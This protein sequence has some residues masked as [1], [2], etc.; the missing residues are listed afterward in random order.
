M[1][2]PVL[3]IRKKDYSL[4]SCIDYQQLNKVTVKNKYPLPMI[5]DLSDQ[6]QGAKFSKSEFLLRSVAFLGHIVSSKGIEV[7]PKKMDAVKSLTRPLSPS[8]IRSFLGLAGYYKRFVEGFSYIASP[9]TS[10]TKK[11]AKFIWSEAF[12]K[13]FQELKDKLTSAPVLT[14]PEGY[15]PQKSNQSQP[16]F[17]LRKFHI[18][19]LFPKNTQNNNAL[20]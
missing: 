17:I 13:S 3:F 11:K 12:E 18:Q 4:Y 2:Y 10:L 7:D 8:D 14:L 9:L 15:M 5:D 6:L 19:P 16:K 20:P 1:G